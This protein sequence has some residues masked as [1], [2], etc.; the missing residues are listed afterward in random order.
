VGKAQIRTALE[1][2]GMAGKAGLVLG[3]AAA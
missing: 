3:T 2:A 1:S